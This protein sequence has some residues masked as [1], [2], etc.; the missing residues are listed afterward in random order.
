M[1]IRQRAVALYF[2]DKVRFE[3]VAAVVRLP[4][5]GWFFSPG[6]FQLALRAGNEKEEGETADTVG[7]CSLRVEHIK[8]YPEIDGQEYVVEFDFLGKD[9]IRYYNKVP[10][11][12]RVPVLP[13]RFFI[14][15]CFIIKSARLHVS[16]ASRRCLRT[17]SCSWR[18]RS[19]TMTCLIASMWAEQKPRRTNPD[20]LKAALLS[21][22][23]V[24]LPDFYSEQ[25]PPGA[26]GRPDGQ[27]FPYL[28]RLDHPAGAAKGADERYAPA[29]RRTSIFTR[30]IK[31]RHF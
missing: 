17:F 29:R 26:D 24:L 10:V 27:S 4:R 28:Q 25:A 15:K 30:W 31:A 21:Q 8:L 16:S 22:S 2:I 3:K 11:E 20:L 5:W 7:C 9:S 18:T 19:P 13:S 1:R 23:S 6:G 14:L 12:K